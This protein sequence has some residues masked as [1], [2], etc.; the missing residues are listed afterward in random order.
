M[1]KNSLAM[2]QQILKFVSMDMHLPL[3]R[4]FLDHVIF[5]M[6]RISLP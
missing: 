6:F 4:H 1:V 3:D 5:Y 2:K